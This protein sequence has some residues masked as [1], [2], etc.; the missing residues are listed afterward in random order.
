MADRLNVTGHQLTIFAFETV[1]ALTYVAFISIAGSLLSIYA[2]VNLGEYI[3]DFGSANVDDGWP[4]IVLL[5]CAVSG[6]AVSFAVG[7]MTA[8]P[9]W[10]KLTS[11]GLN[12]RENG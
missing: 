9:L 2:L 11:P 6:F 12:G 4:G 8:K 5:L 7:C 10:K 3:F 1:A